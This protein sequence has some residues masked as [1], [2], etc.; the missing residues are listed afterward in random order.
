MRHPAKHL[1]LFL[2]SL[3][4]AGW[5]AV[6]L[7]LTMNAAFAQGPVRDLSA[8]S[9][10]IYAGGGGSLSAASGAGM[11]ATVANFLATKG[12]GAA[13]LASLVLTAT[14]VNPKSGV[15]DLKFGQ[16]LAG[17]GVY[18]TYVKAAFDGDGNLIHLI[19]NLADLSGRG[20]V[21]A[22]AAPRDALNEAMLRNHPGVIVGLVEGNRSGNVVSFSGGGFFHRDPTVTRVAIAMENGLIAAGFLVETW[23]NRGNMLHHTLVGGSGSVLGVELRTNNV[24]DKYKIFPDHPDNSSQ[25][26]E[27][28]PGACDLLILP[29]PLPCLEG[30]QEGYLASRDRKRVGCQ[31]VRPR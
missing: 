7:S 16:A 22:T 21:S 9:A 27:A 30:S 8:Q 14:H 4:A 3:V 15:T 23:T 29:L 10:N 5:L 25:T 17:L 24:N 6:A 19:E 20:V 31:A 11:P 26:V 12:H 13:T 18:G 28:G 1:R 2:I